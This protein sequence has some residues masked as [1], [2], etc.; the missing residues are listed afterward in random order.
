MMTDTQPTLVIGHRN[1]DTD[2]IAAALGY[3]FVL[4]TIGP[5]HYVAGRAVGEINAQAAFVL[6]RFGLS[7]PDLVTDVEPHLGDLAE[8]LETVTQDQPL[9]AAA[10][11]MGKPSYSYVP[12]VDAQGKALGMLSP[13][14]LFGVIADGLTSDTSGANVLAQ[15]MSQKLA[16]PVET[17]LSGDPL[18][19]SA[20]QSVHDVINQVLRADQVEF[21]IVDSEGRYV[22]VCRKWALL[23]PPR[24][25]VVLVDHN[26]PAQAV[27]GLENAELVEVLDHHRLGNLPTTLPMRFLA[28]PVGSTST[29]VTE[30]A[31]EAGVTLPAPIAGVLLGGIM[32][33]T[34]VFRSPT[35]TPRDQKAARTLAVLAGLAP[36]DQPEKIESAIQEF[37]QAVLA[38]GAGLGARTAHELVRTD[39]KAYEA[40]GNTAQISQVEVANFDELPARL[41]DLQ[42]A[43]NHLC[44]DEKLALA[45][46]TVTDV[47]RGD[48]RIIASGQPR[49]IAALPFKTLQDGT[50]DAPGVVSRKKQLLPPVLEALAQG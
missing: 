6:A 44:A 31:L 23:T 25:R 5:D 49:I 24:R 48:S 14:D 28:D 10:L 22:G 39:L 35:T 33:D 21:L 11:L 13:A 12:V 50:L 3:A 19:F 36:A 40:N 41:A 37:G 43:L 1:P 26:E 29:L 9:S 7:A 16:Q 8:R 20:D 27:S 4:D 15:A 30:R 38:A 42:M 32:S 47:V 18:M 45:L 46:F 17:A 2:A 34:L